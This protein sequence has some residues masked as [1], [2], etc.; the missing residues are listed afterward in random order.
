LSILGGLDTFDLDKRGV[1]V[2]VAHGTFV[3]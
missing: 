2:L 3:T 1:G